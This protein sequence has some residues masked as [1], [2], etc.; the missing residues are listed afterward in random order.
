MDGVLLAR[1]RLKCGA[2]EELFHL[3]DGALFSQIGH[4]FLFSDEIV[5]SLC[6]L[7]IQ[8]GDT[9][10]VLLLDLSH[11]NIFHFQIVSDLLKRYLL[12]DD[13]L[14]MLF[15]LIFV[16]I[17]HSLKSFN[18][19]L[20]EA[21]FTL[22]L[23]HPLTYILHLEP[24]LLLE[25]NVLSYLPLIVLELLIVAGVDTGNAAASVK[26]IRRGRD[27]LFGADQCFVSIVHSH[28]H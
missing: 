12:H 22:T 27:G 15:N 9:F 20:E 25:L 21:D 5:G 13:F 17:D 6:K 14:H 23:L 1:L 3:C 2:A 19:A 8:G 26:A 7:L 24:H 4:L 10:L 18:L 11:S 16:A 28:L